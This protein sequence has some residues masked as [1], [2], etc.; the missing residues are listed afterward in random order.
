[1]SKISP[2]TY[3]RNINS[4]REY[5]F[6]LSGY[7]PFIINRCFAGF[8]DC[9][10]FAE[11]MNQAHQLSPALQYDFYYYGIRKGSRFDP[12]PKPTEPEGLEVVM[13]YFDYSKQKALEVIS[14][15]TK[16]DLCD[17][18]KSMDKGGR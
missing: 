15:L 12:I 8:I 10:M 18:I 17:M 14:L 2:F 3:V 11:Q 5:D 1:M 16:Q 13:A 6:D 7:S 4:K 9:I